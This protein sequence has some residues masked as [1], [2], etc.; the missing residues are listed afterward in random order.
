LNVQRNRNGGRSLKSVVVCVRCTFSPYVGQGRRS[1]TFRGR[2]CSGAF[3]VVTNSI[4]G[5]P[6][7]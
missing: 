3:S 7:R 5:E 4:V 2:F 6:R 1:T